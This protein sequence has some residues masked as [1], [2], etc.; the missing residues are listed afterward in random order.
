MGLYYRPRQ[1][2]F[3]DS[4]PNTTFIRPV[5]LRQKGILPAGTA[6]ANL[7]VF[8]TQYSARIELATTDFLT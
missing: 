5:T 1:N 3:Q 2:V 6:A 4:R 7:L 8:T